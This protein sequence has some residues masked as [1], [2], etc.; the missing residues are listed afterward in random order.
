MDTTHIKERLEGDETA[1]INGASRHS[2]QVEILNY[3][4][5]SNENDDVIKSKYVASSQ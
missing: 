4:Q 1:R 3:S 2:Q 5:E